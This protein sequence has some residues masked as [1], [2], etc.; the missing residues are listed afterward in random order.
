[1]AKSRVGHSAF[2]RGWGCAVFV[3]VGGGVGVGDGGMGGGGGGDGAV[4]VAAAGRDGK[5]GGDDEIRSTLPQR[6]PGRRLPL[7]GMSRPQLPHTVPPTS[8]PLSLRD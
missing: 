8:L 2:F 6:L 7:I 3:V 5:D 1:M 4:V